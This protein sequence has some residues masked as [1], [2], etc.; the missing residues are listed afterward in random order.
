MWYLICLI[1]GYIIGLLITC[2]LNRRMIDINKS[3]AI[4]IYYQ[5][6]TDLVEK[7]ELYFSK[8][9]LNEENLKKCNVFFDE[10]F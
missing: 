2:F 10:R 6:E 8:D 4:R 1:I 7:L 3:Q 5:P 9:S